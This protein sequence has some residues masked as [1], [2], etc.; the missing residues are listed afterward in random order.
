MDLT[1]LTKEDALSMKQPARHPLTPDTAQERWRRLRRWSPTPAIRLSLAAHGL[2]AAAI[3]LAPQ[4]WLHVLAGLA[5][6]HAALSCGMLPRSGM[7]GRN[8]RRL[9]PARSG[10]VALT[11]DDGPDP[12]I[13]PR[14]LD[15][16]DSFGAKA[17]FFVIGDRAE[18]QPELLRD[19]LR[20]GHG[21]ENHTHR[22][23]MAFACLGPVRQWREIHRAQRAI[24]E[25]CGQAPR[26]FR[27]PMG[28]RNP[29][30]DPALAVE[31][32]QLV[33]WTRRGLDTLRQEPEAVLARLTRGLA[34]GDILLL[35]DGSSA[36]DGQGRPL[37]LEVLPELLRRIAA[38]GLT[39]TSLAG[40]PP[41]DGAGAARAAG[42]ASPGRDGCACR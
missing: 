17:S 34:A 22:H 27:A 11:F 32:L 2:G 3:A 33:S 14:I 37:V 18:R 31:G 13:T 41:P 4:V 10:H 5:V 7:L 16:L 36:R 24:E 12:E 35:H 28:L 8:L 21:V 15:M 38:A 9:P 29:L 40:A 30:L 20:R 1:A 6:N 26:F 23:P 39:A 25:A 19:M 42:A